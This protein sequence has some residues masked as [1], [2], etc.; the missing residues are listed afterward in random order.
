MRTGDFKDYL[1]QDSWNL[2]KVMQIIDRRLFSLV[3]VVNDS[4][5]LVGA[6][7][8]GDIRR[9]I[10]RGCSAA[11][12]VK[13][14]MNDSPFVLQKRDL[15]NNEVVK[16]IVK[17]M[18]NEILGDP[19]IPVVDPSN[20]PVDIVSCSE[21]MRMKVSDCGEPRYV[22]KVLVVGGAGFLGSVLVGRLLD[23]G[24]QVRVLDNLMYGEDSIRGFL[25]DD[26][27]ELFKGDMRNISAVVEALKG[28][29]A[30]INLAAI[31]GDP[32]CCLDPSETIETNYLANKILA[33]ACKYNQINRF[34]FASTCSVYGDS[35][36][37]ADENSA[38]DPLSLYT[39]SK[40]HSEEGILSLE[41]ENFAPTIFRMATL[42]GYSPRMRFD[43]V[44][45]TM[46][47]DA[48]CYGMIKVHGGG[49]QWRPLL[50]V[51][52]ATDAYIKCLEAP[53]EE[54]KGEIFNVGSEEQNYQICDIA[55]VI[56]GQVPNTQVV[57][58]GNIIDARDYFVS[59]AKIRKKLGFEPKGSIENVVL[60][61]KEAIDSKRITDVSSKKYCNVELI[62]SEGDR[63][64]GIV[65]KY[66]EEFADPEERSDVEYIQGAN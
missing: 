10:I 33:E 30:V 12:S 47:R 61:I 7:S 32:A 39:H 66:V 11:S 2:K 35:K 8:D 48:V 22:K 20:R 46:T 60:E 62:R 25:H 50:E 41:D 64:D 16:R 13:E 14:V 55:E 53:L 52:D 63:R 19:L 28:V 31:V 58:D 1:V 43:L 56:G 5:Q 49:K 38:M 57:V 34:I 45:N 51:G 36:D 27:F 65:Q 18:L 6:V 54:V 23:N 44:V 9:A 26:K 37:I 17:T 59:F 29:D 24:Y 42:Y 40:I 21:L 4:G 3:F 15:A